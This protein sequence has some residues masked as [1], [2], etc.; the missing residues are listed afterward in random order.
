M[1]S[2]TLAL[3]LSRFGIRVHA[4]TPSIVRDTRA[5]DH[6]M[7][8]EFSRRLFEKAEKKA[9]LG[10]VTPADIAPVAVFLARPEAAKITAQAISI[11][12]GIS[13]G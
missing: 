3:E 11:N 2:K 10:V 4:L 1:F 12:G 7:S 8:E 13:A 6:M 9:K 5:Y